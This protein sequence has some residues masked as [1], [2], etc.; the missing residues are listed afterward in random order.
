MGSALVLYLL[1]L[2]QLIN[3]NSRKEILIVKRPPFPKPCWLAAAPK[4]MHHG[5]GE[6]R[7]HQTPK[8]FLKYIYSSPRASMRKEITTP[9]PGRHSI[10]KEQKGCL[11]NLP[12]GLRNMY[13][14]P[15]KGGNFAASNETPEENSHSCNFGIR[16]HVSPHL[17]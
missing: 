5:G 15:W 2:L 7:I 8:H 10:S 12:K 9:S 14:P 3:L 17:L 4:R 11:Q 13:H 6:Q 16:S 1:N